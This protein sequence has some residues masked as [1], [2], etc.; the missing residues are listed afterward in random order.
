[1]LKRLFRKIA[2]APRLVHIPVG[3][4]PLQHYPGYLPQDTELVSRY[5]SGQAEIKEDHYIDGFGVRTD[6]TCVPFANPS[7]LDVEKLQ[8]PLPD[9]GFHAEGIEYAAL[10]DSFENR[11]A[12]GRFTAVEVGSGWGPWIGLAGVLAKTHG[13]DTLCL[14][15][16]EASAERYA[17]MCRHL[18]LNELT[19]ASGRII[20]TFHG[21]IWT[22]DGEVQFPDSDV[23][24]MGPAV[25]A[26]GSKTDYRGRRV[27]TLSTPCARLSTLCEGAGLIDFLHIDV[28][29][30]ELDII[31]NDAEWLAKNVRAMM[32]ATH[33]RVIEG[34]VMDLLGNWG[35]VLKREKPCRFRMDD[36]SCDNWERLTEADGSQHWV[37]PRL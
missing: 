8:L 31:R 22:H 27:T 34:G 30:S 6:F 32:V 19:S 9:D 33:S 11:Q 20:K 14:I 36:N 28:Q 1:M 10:L 17:L 29:G 13:A 25:T 3:C 18:E 37:N 24:D 4:P 12:S 2:P 35:W 23:E 21:A 7:H 15:G 26:Q 16:A 5:A